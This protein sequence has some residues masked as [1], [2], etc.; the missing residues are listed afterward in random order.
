MEIIIEQLKRNE[1]TGFVHEVIF[2]TK[3]TQGEDEV[4]RSHRIKFEEKETFSQFEE[5][6]ESEVIAW[7]KK[8]KGPEELARIE[9][10]L[11]DTLN[12]TKLTTGKPWEAAEKQKNHE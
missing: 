12:K 7:V 2:A 11:L 1:A 8:F 4:S 6:T 9:T 5:L 10:F 3:V